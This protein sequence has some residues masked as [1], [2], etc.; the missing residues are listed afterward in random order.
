[1]PILFPTS[2]A[3]DGGCDAKSITIRACFSSMPHSTNL[4]MISKLTVLLIG[5]QLLNYDVLYG[6]VLSVGWC[7]DE[8]GLS[9]V[10]LHLVVNLEELIVQSI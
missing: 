1:M 3:F 10:L 5:P 7:S 4:A 6:H 8:F 9:L 2:D